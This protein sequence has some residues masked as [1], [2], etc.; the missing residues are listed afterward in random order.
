MFGKR[1]D[2]PPK[3]QR[4]ASEFESL[5]RE[6][7]AALD[8]T[9]LVM[10]TRIHYGDLIN[11]KQ[12]DEPPETPAYIEYKPN[13]GQERVRGACQRFIDDLTTVLTEFHPEINGISIY[14][15]YPHVLRA[16]LVINPTA[17]ISD[18]Q[19]FTRKVL[20]E[21]RDTSKVYVIRYQR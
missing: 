4:K 20:A 10:H 6:V 9:G 1:K 21:I 7:R 13:P 5:E 16:R 17:I 18:E 3:A 15:P 2:E 11:Q 19:D 14:S 12:P 8:A